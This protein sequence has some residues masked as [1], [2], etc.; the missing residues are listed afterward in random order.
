MT[1]PAATVGPRMCPVCSGP[2]RIDLDSLYD[3]RYG[4]PGTYTILA[5]SRCSHRFLDATFTADELGSQYTDYYPRS[6]RTLESYRP[7]VEVDGF[8]AWI[9]GSRASAFRWVP[10]D[11]KVLDVG[12]GFGE[13]LAYHEAR[14][15]DAHGI[16]PDANLLRVADRYGLQAKVGLF[17]ASLYEPTSFDYV[18]LD[19]V[20]EHV[21]D[22]IDL[23]R[24][25][26]TVLRPGGTAIVATPNARGYGARLLGK[27]WINWHVPYHRQHFNRRSLRLAAEQAGF[28]VLSI[29]TITSSAWA[30][31]Q[32]FH[33]LG[34]PPHEVPSA[35]WAPERSTMTIPGK[36]RRGMSLA[37]RFRLFDGIS[38]LADAL[39]TGDNLLAVLERR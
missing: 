27:S 6:S 2:A 7:P 15:C 36:V 8:D 13:T 34:R 28:E 3:D 23:L 32:G 26:H 29:R 11:V 10:R 33:L 21:G 39:G 1:L 25:V 19:Q 16:D 12:C 9:A 14:G 4:Y 17:S 22:P 24:D 18:T 38:R 31:Y 35:F 5:C 37:A 20:V 30:M